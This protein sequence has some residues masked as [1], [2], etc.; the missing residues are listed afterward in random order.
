MAE[1][2]RLIHAPVDKVWD[3]L[4]D[5]WLYA[6]WVVGT[7]HIRDVDGTWPEPGSRL[8]HSSGLWPLLINDITVVR[9]AEPPHLLIMKPQLWPLGRG[10]ITL[11]LRPADHG[12]TSVILGEDFEQGPLR[13]ALVRGNDLLLHRR[14]VEALRRLA[15]LAA[16]R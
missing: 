4:A 2:Q 15:D 10:V 7:P 12:R 1:V 9:V 3:V 16:H 5:G 14:N 8:H 11:R 13:W 6:S